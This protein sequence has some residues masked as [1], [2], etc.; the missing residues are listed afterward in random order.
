VSR[1]LLVRHGQAS[2][3]DA[4]YDKL[5]ALGETQA[6]LLGEFWAGRAVKFDFAATGPL[7]R[8]K[9]TARIVA[10]AYRRAGAAFPEPVAAAEFNECD[11]EGVIRQALPGLL[12]TSQRARELQQAFLSAKT[13]EQRSKTFQRVVEEVMAG[14]VSGLLAVDGVESWAEFS[15]RVNR[16][17]SQFIARCGR[18]TTAAIFTSGG[19]IAVA[20][21][22][23]LNLAP[24]DTLRVMW[25]SR[26]CSY[27][28]FLFSGARFTLSAFNAS[29]HLGE[30]AL[31]TY[32]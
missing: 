7:T 32:R 13:P 10:E 15:A 20:L 5:S 1:L 30:E 9:H 4:D 2:F 26:N 6:R 31:V 25:M 29:P 16:G 23:A 17:V 28:E 12:E 11:A 19:P 18:G 8:Q 14:W 24:L 27:S 22:R 21:E 3:L